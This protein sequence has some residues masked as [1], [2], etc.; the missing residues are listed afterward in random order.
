MTDT[1]G[2]RLMAIAE[3]VFLA[4]AAYH[5]QYGDVLVISKHRMAVEM[6]GERIG[7]YFDGRS[8]CYQINR[9]P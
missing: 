9:G 1:E 8:R 7:G 2:W 4:V 6:T 5:I 3:L